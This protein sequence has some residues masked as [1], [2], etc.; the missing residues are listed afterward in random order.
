MRQASPRPS[1]NNLH[2]PEAFSYV[3]LSSSL[4]RCFPILVFTD[5]NGG[6]IFHNPGT[7]PKP[8]LCC[9][10][11]LAAS[12]VVGGGTMSR[13]Y[14]RTNQCLVVTFNN[15]TSNNCP[16]H[17]CR[18]SAVVMRC[19]NPR[20]AKGVPRWSKVRFGKCTSCPVLRTHHTQ[21]LLQNITSNLW[22]Y[23]GRHA[24][25]R[26]TAALLEVTLVQRN[27]GP[28]YLLLSTVILVYPPVPAFSSPA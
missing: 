26:F 7:S 16:L 6:G 22:D 12:D 27:I 28:V 11:L 17:H 19:T 25:L 18:R 14:R 5:P 3:C 21:V 15:M 9:Q 4:P 1:Q 23:E 10:L 13:Y 24:F 8:T 2:D 20:N